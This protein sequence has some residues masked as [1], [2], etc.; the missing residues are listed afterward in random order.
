MLGYACHHEDP[1]SAGSFLDC[2]MLKGADALVYSVA[3]QLGV[4]PQLKFVFAVESGVDTC[5]SALTSSPMHA[6][7][8]PATRGHVHA[9]L[10]SA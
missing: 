2:D 8:M 7:A 3:Q 5:M 10:K 1:A 9:V 6:E 4:H